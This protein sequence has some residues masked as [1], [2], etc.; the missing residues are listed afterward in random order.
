MATP[1]YMRRF[2]EW[3]AEEI[4]ELIDELELKVRLESNPMRR[5]NYRGFVWKYKARLTELEGA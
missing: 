1:R 2:E 3:T 4:R 5:S